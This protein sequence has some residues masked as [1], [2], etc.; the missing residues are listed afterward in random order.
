MSTW[1]LDAPALYAALDTVRQHLGAS[2]RE[3]GALLDVS[4]SSLTRL[5]QGQRLDADSL[6][7]VLMWLNAPVAR[8][9]I[10]P[11]DTTPST[12]QPELPG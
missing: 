3:L 7:T 5:S 8:F 9:A 12:D 2:W 4:A 10:G 6:V 11:A 1:K